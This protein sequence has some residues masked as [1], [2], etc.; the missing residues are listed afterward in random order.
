MTNEIHEFTTVDEMIEMIL[1]DH[2]IEKYEEELLLLSVPSFFSTICVMIENYCS[3][4]HENIH[5]MV[6]MMAT[7]IHEMNA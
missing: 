3:H 7:A 2:F 6:D 1:A 5:D 4:H